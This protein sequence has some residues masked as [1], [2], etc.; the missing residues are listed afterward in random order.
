LPNNDRGDKEAYRQQG[1]PI[2][3]LL[4]FQN[5][6]SRIKINMETDRE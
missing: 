6:L 2:I 3:L 4:F 5:K 1:Y